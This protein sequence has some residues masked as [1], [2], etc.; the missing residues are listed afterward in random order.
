MAFKF[1]T[2]KTIDIDSI[3]TEYAELR[4][5]KGIIENRLEQLAN[6]IKDYS[7]KNGE[8][9][10]KGSFYCSND[11]YIFGAVAKSKITVDT[12]KLT[13]FLRKSGYSNAVKKEVNYFVDEDVLNDLV[14]NGEIDEE[15]LKSFATTKINYAI[16]LTEKEKMPQIEQ[17]ILRR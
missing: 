2:K 16:S 1:K 10:S 17:S 15:D 11:N 5:K 6:T 8:K 3:V 7:Y 12:E 4:K 14:A 13:N 9:D